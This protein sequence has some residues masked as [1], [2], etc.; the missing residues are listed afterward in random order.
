MTGNKKGIIKYIIIFI[1]IMLFI[2]I[3]VL[4]LLAKEKMGVMRS[5]V[6]R[7]SLFATTWFTPSNLK[8]IYY[9]LLIG[10]MISL[11]L[12]I[13]SFIYNSK[14]NMKYYICTMVLNLIAIT[15][16]STNAIK[17]L[18]T[19]HFLLIAILVSIMIRYVMIINN[20]RSN[21]L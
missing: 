7:K 16:I 6:Y 18:Y 10:I 5:L 20:F 4:E 9:M 21:K 19:F 13:F 1:E 3:I 17:Q 14:K 8:V 12:I 2:S 15:S 11:I